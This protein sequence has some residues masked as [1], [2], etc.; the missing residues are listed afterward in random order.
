MIK[1]LC[2]VDGEVIISKKIPDGTFSQN[3]MGPTLGVV[4]QSKKFVAPIAGEVVIMNGHAFGIKGENGVQ[5]LVHIGIDTVKIE[6]K[7]KAKIFKHKVK[8]GDKVKAGQLMVEVD[9]DGIKKC[10]YSIITPICVIGDS[11]EN[12]DVTY[13]WLGDA[14][15]SD[16][17][18]KVNDYEK[19]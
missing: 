8:Q 9:L 16:V 18:F 17:I 3:L 1:I 12:K 13:E 4:P 19:I 5:V 11:V 14:T 6:E 10:G 15:T 2:P 7:Q